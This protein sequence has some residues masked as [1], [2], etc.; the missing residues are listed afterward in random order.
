MN[1][2]ISLMTKT[3]FFAE[4]IHFIW[5]RWSKTICSGI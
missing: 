5:W 3:S 1:L 4:N 2:K